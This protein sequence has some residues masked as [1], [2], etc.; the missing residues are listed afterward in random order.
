MGFMKLKKYLLI[1]FG[2]LTFMFTNPLISIADT[3]PLNSEKQMLVAS[4]NQPKK[5]KSEPENRLSKSVDEWYDEKIVFPESSKYG[6]FKSSLEKRL[7]NDQKLSALTKELEYYDTDFSKERVQELI[8]E[9]DDLAMNELL[10]SFGDFFK[11]ETYLGRKY[12]ILERKVSAFF[13]AGFFKR[14]GEEGKF[15]SFG[16]LDPDELDKKSEIELSFGGFVYTDKSLK[17]RVLQAAHL[18]SIDI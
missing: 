7:I 11:E 12:A 17:E 1:I 16:Q 4:L 9:R 14:E 3:K 2:S 5:K 18:A 10:S 8:D 15:Y 13:K 6:I